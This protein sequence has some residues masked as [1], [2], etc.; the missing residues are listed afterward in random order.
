MISK[1][2]IPM[3]INPKRLSAFCFGAGP[4]ERLAGAGARPGAR[5]GARDGESVGRL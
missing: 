3:I 1:M 4:G 5:P 2:A